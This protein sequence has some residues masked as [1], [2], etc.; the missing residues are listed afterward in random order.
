M[1]DYI[2]PISL[3]VADGFDN[4]PLVANASPDNGDADGDGVGDA[5][6]NCRDISNNAQTDSND[7][8]YGD[9]CDAIGAINIDE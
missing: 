9:A 3:G 2:K 5:C 1:I 8:M 6:D 7:N 4:C